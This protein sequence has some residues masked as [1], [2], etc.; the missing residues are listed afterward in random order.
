MRIVTCVH[1]LNLDNIDNDAENKLD[2]TIG[3][4]KTCMSTITNSPHKQASNI[5]DVVTTA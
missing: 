1:I 5:E 3:K 2:T 4:P